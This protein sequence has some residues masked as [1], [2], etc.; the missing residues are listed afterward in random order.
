M[1]EDNNSG[2]A[3][4]PQLGKENV[5]VIIASSVASVFEWF[6][7]FLYGALAVII[8]RN[9]F[10][11]VNETTS[12]VLALLAF[13]AGF[14]VRPFGAVVFGFFGDLLGR[15]NTFLVTLALM[16]VAT[17]CVGLLPTYQQIGAA[18]PW[19]LVAL[20]MLQGLSVGGVYGGAATYV[21]EHVDSRRRGFF[22]SWIQITA[23]VGMAL[24]LTV[25]F[26]TRT[27][28]GE[29]HFNQWGWRVPFLLSILLLGL[30]IWI[31]MRL[32]ES[33]VYLEMKASGKASKQ[34][35]TDAFGNW[36]N[37]RLILIALFGSMVGQAVIWYAAQFYVFFFM[38][39]ILKV[40]AALTNV[41][42]A[43]ALVISTPLYVFFGWLS[44]RIGR[45]PVILGAC[46]LA[47]LTY[48]PLFKALTAA[49]NPAMARAVATAPVTV[50]ADTRECTFQFDP[51]GTAKF[52]SSCDIAR[53]YLARAGV[54]YTT[55][56]SAPGS[57]AQLRVGE[58]VLESFRGEALSG[59]ELKARRADWEKQAAALVAD[60]GYPLTA[61]RDQINVPMVLLILVV[62]MSFSAMVYGPMA[63]LLT[64]L[65]PAK[66]RYTSMSLPYHLGTGWFGGFL[67]PV[68]FAIVAATGN[69][70]SG[71]WYPLIG[72]VVTLICGVLLLPETK[73]R[74]LRC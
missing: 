52:S 29:E 20:R 45:R 22:T 14:A 53:S 33:P 16:G 30:T 55:E 32:S 18:A 25:I 67:P 2:A 23:T 39:R 36:T 13:A 63:A 71:L 64:E 37:V 54:S 61:A 34:P 65:F 17:F 57:V 69:I 28:V 41:L 59:A 68:A 46:L 73:G 11:S 5:K 38:E 3:A 1:T 7:F 62:L 58:Q 26:A 21:A 4:A 70:Y 56:A 66:V 19:I 48:F 27:I 31:Q 15:K 10:S 51:I 43:V 40:D 44:D 74:D 8:S 49:A 9:F 60:S 72:A 24:S 42:V 6:D 12:F 50:L 47:A 35:L